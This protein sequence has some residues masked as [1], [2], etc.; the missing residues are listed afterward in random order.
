MALAIVQNFK[1]F[2]EID[3]WNVKISSLP[4]WKST[5]Y[6]QLR[7]IVISFAEFTEDRVS[8]IASSLTYFSALSIVPVLAMIF[9]IAQGF[10]LEEY[11]TNELNKIFGDTQEGVFTTALDYAKRMIATAKGG[12]ITGI[13]FTFL[14]YAVIRLMSNI[15]TAFNHIWGAKGRNWDRKL[16]DYM[17][18]IVFGPLL[19][20]LSGSVTTFI[21]ISLD[22]LSKV[23]NLLDYL[24]PLI[25]F[26]RFIIIWLLFMLLYLIFPNTSVKVMPALIAGI[27][28]GTLYQLVQIGWI[29]SQVYLTNYNVIY[30]GFALVPLF[31]IW[32]HLSWTIILF[33]AEYAFAMQNATIWRHKSKSIK[34][35]NEHHRKVTILILRHIVKAFETGDPPL[36]LNQLSN[37]VDIPYRFV[38]NVCIEMEKAGILCKLERRDE[39]VFQPAIDISKLDMVTVIEKLDKVGFSK[40]KTDNDELYQKIEKM[41][42]DI[43]ETIK[44]SKSN[45]L[46]KKI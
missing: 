35:S 18:I 29:K 22:N 8:S 14:V 32:L 30:G 20:I 25:F 5:L 34:M 41:T 46:I 1:Q 43:N 6:Q 23:Y 16:A 44:T 40:L 11:L 27:L 3:L 2:F 45:I 38:R 12:V 19:L 15:E 24:K 9:G 33:G 37:K 10:G 42:N 39:E 21:E 26:S 7:I 31:F 17:A 36:N 28:A 4:K 13:S